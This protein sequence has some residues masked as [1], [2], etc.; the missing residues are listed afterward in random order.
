MAEVGGKAIAPLRA[1][2]AAALARLA[3]TAERDRGVRDNA[4][5]AATRVLLADDAAVARDP[6]IGPALLDAALDGLPL[7]EDF[8]EAR[9]AYGG[10]GALL[11]LAG[12][13]PHVAA[14]APR[15]VATLARAAAEE[16][17][18]RAKSKAKSNAGGEARRAAGE[19][20]GATDETLAEIGA[21]VARAS[22]RAPEVVAAAVAAAPPEHQT[23]LRALVGS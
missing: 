18:R 2:L 22:A 20:N 3:S 23:A 9:A 7:E 12:E 17:A 21:A 8:E 13:I 6:T 14:R 10:V 19:A 5:S 1:D 16:T 15:L 4:A 11:D